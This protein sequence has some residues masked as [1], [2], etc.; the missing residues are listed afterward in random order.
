MLDQLQQQLKAYFA[1]KLKQFDL[2][3][4]MPGTASQQQVWQANPQGIPVV[5][6]SSV[7][8]LVKEINHCQCA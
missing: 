3:L 5:S 1:G 8:V 2:P 7:A 4:L 6:R